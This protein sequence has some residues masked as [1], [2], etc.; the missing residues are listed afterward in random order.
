[1]F[2]RVYV[3]KI[4]PHADRAQQRDDQ[5]QKAPAP[6]SRERPDTEG[7]AAL[8]A[9]A[10]KTYGLELDGTR[11]TQPSD[12]E[13][14][15]LLDRY[16]LAW[17]YLN[18]HVSGGMLP[19]PAAQEQAVTLSSRP[20]LKIRAACEVLRNAAKNYTERPI[21]SLCGITEFAT[22]VL[23]M[24]IHMVGNCIQ[25]FAE[26][27]NKLFCQAGRLKSEQDYKAYQ[28]PSAAAKKSVESYR[29]IGFWMFD[30]FERLAQIPGLKFAIM[31]V[32]AATHAGVGSRAVLP[33]CCI[34]R[35]MATCSL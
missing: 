31:H 11:N 12:A 20:L 14:R 30:A 9:T 25:W 8:M 33:H 13:I 2:K 18:R 3:L 34:C 16:R 35:T 6:G 19:E 1:V 10:Q 17:N 32:Y 29:K 24:H 21:C 22:D 5:P 4:Y 7:M 26:R 15:S 23:H 27:L 28:A